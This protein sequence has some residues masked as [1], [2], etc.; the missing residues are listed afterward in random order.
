M[1]ARRLLKSYGSQGKVKIPSGPAVFDVTTGDTTNPY[2]E[3]TIQFVP[4]PMSSLEDLTAFGLDYFETGFVTF[5]IAEV[6]TTTLN[7][8][9]NSVLVLDG[10]DVDIQ[11]INTV[12]RNGKT[13][14]FEA[15]V[16]KGQ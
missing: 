1:T 12:K 2:M 11:K 10:I 4:Y 14:A 8:G 7:I 3:Y 6:D 9:I 15:R 13:L 16:N 5:M